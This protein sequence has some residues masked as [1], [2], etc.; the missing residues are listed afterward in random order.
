MLNFFFIGIKFHQITTVSEYQS[1]HLLC[2]HR[3]PKSMVSP[4]KIKYRTLDRHLKL[5]PDN[6]VR[7]FTKHLFNFHLCK[8]VTIYTFLLKFVKIF[9]DNNSKLCLDKKSGIDI[10]LSR[11]HNYLKSAL[12]V[13]PWRN[14]VTPDVSWQQQS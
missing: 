4:V 6:E 3:R 8:T 5:H 2:L 1:F 7:K 9:T 11:I 12:I 13:N 14:H 10:P